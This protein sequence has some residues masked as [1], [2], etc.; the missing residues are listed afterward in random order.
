MALTTPDA[1]GGRALRTVVGAVFA[2]ALAARATIVGAGGGLRGMGNYDDGVYF[3][4][5]MALLHGRLPYR[6]FLFLQPPGILVALAPS[7]ALSP[8]VGDADAFVAARLGFLV[9]G[10]LNSVLVVLVLRRFGATAAV[11]GGVFYALFLAAAHT[12][13]STLLEP[14]GTF[15]TLVALAVL[16]RPG[17]EDEPLARRGRTLLVVAGVALGLGVT[18]KIFFVVAALVVVV[19]ARR[20]AGWLFVGCVASGLS[21]GSLALLSPAAAWQQVVLDQLGRPRLSTSSVGRVVSIMWVPKVPD[22]RAE[23]LLVVALVLVVA[24]AV[25]AVRARG[26]LLPVLLLAAA[27]PVLL[28]A[29]SYYRHYAV[30]VAMPL[31]LV[32]GIGAGELVRRVALPGRRV[33]VAVGTVLVLAAVCLGG[34]RHSGV[35][36]F[37]SPPLSRGLVQSVRSVPGC[38][39]SDDPSVLLF[40]GTLTR[41]LD[42]G[43]PFWPDT[44]GWLYDADEPPPSDPLLPPEENASWQRHAYTYFTSGEATVLVRRKDGLGAETRARIGE[45]K[46]WNKG[47]HVFRAFDVPEVSAPR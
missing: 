6:D 14:V 34:W 47:R 39:T 7:A 44:T 20:R 15:G 31:A 40:A 18:T 43:C 23:R 28:S 32:V 11:A 4:A 29:P 45:T 16:L 12:E 38:V 22:V 8:L 46:S 42:Q 9:L 19:W 26:G 17:A 1:L 10:S 35:R 25:L 3:S 24:M 36:D 2:L 27:Y 41:T 33:P 5:S 13:R 37:V 30:L 21:V